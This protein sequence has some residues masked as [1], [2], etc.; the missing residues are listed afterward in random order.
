M[1]CNLCPR[2]CGALRTETEG[3][4]LCGMPERP[5]VARAALHLWEEPPLSVKSGEG[6]FFSC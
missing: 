4:G 1:I 3:Y 5:V 6:R 2:G